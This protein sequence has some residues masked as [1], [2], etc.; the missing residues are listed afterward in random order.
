MHLEDSEQ[1]RQ[2]E[3]AVL[4]FLPGLS[5]ITELYESLKS[6]RR[7]YDTTKYDDSIMTFFL[8]RQVQSYLLQFMN[9]FNLS[10]M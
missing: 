10:H 5:D 9:V 2:V 4:I 6:D 8:Y 3:G 7:F 1:F